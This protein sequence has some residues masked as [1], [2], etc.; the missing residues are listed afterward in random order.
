MNQQ[1]IKTKIRD[2]LEKNKENYLEFLKHLISFDSRML[3]NGKKGKEKAVQDYL[4]EVLQKKGG[5]LDCFAPENER[6]KK[7][8]GFNKNHEYTDRENVV[9]VFKGNGKGRSLLMN[10][11]CDVVTPGNEEE[12]TSPPFSAEI[13]DGKLYGRGST[14]MKAGLSAAIL[15]IDLLQEAGFV[16]QGDIIFESVVDEEGGGNGTIACCD[17]GYRADGAL[18][19]EPTCLQVMPANRGAFLA[20]FL[21]KGKPVHASMRGFGINAIDK[22]IKLINGL[23]ELELEWLLVKRHPLLDNPTINIGQISGGEGASIVPAECIVKMDV[24]FFPTEYNDDNY[25]IVDPEDIKREVQKKVDLICMGDEWL[26]GHPVTIEWYQETLCFQTDLKNEFVNACKKS[27]KNVLGKV[28]VNGLPCG[29]DG[30]Q[31]AHIG[32]MPVVVLGPGDIRNAHTTDE[33]VNIVEF[34]NSIEIYANLIVDW[35]GIV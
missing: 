9:A 32:K 17:R 3:E 26:A 23:R 30:A 6:I 18:L 27:C 11:H 25:E 4:K 10:G 20:Q 35:V 22:A 13:R 7:Y 16:F 34:F 8:P 5:E 21:V 1:L 14:D 24:E 2:I 29:C 15:A 12:W 28:V 31:L 33:F 19:M